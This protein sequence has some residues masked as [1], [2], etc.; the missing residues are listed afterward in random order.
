MIGFLIGAACGA[1]ELIL[2]IRVGRAVQNQKTGPILGYIAL[3]FLLYACAFVPVVLFFKNQLLWCGVGTS[4]VLV[5]GAFFV[6]WK[7]QR[8]GKGDEKS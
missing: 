1:G 2:L 3:K 8:S 6:N 7:S 4:S 5:I